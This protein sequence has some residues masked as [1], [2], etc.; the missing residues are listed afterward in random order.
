M[1]SLTT[2]RYYESDPA[3]GYVTPFG[4]VYRCDKAGHHTIELE[5][6][7]LLDPVW[8]D[9]SLNKQYQY[10]SDYVVFV[11]GWVKVS[12]SDIH[13]CPVLIY[14]KNLTDRQLYRLF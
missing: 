12:Y 10:F 8:V 13:K 2:Q 9:F 6:K 3:Y 1:S 11:K 5:L 4:K 7:G 14:T